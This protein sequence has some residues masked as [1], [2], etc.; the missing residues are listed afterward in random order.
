MVHLEFHNDRFLVKLNLGFNFIFR[1]LKY[2][3]KRASCKIIVV[4]IN[5]NVVKKMK[6]PICP[7]KGR[8]KIPQDTKGPSDKD[9]ARDK[10]IKHSK[11]PAYSISPQGVGTKPIYWD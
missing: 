2:I 6:F 1:L 9:L 7:M 11:E 8:S 10:N 3:P 4:N 5:H